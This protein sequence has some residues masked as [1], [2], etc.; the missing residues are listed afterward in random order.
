MAVLAALVDFLAEL[1]NSLYCWL[2]SDSTSPS[3]TISVCLRPVMGTVDVVPQPMMV[4][5]TSDIRM[6][7]TFLIIV[8]FKGLIVF[9]GKL[10]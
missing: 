7:F 6:N 10:G 9:K 4:A 3:L 2:A 1:I 8:M 5:A